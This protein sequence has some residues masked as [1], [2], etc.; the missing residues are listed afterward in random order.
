MAEEK[1]TVKERKLEYEISYIKLNKHG[2][3]IYY[4][5]EIS[6]W[7]DAKSYFEKVCKSKNFS[8]LQLKIVQKFYFKEIDG[9]LE[10]ILFCGHLNDLGISDI[11]GLIESQKELV[12]RRNSLVIEF[13]VFKAYIEIQMKDLQERLQEGCN[14]FDE[15]FNS[16]DRVI[17][18]TTN[19]LKNRQEKIDKLKN[20]GILIN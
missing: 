18:E 5:K 6:S 7:E 2:E 14:E 16:I 4:K 1:L 8:G 11:T 19:L 17:G 3:P 10:N 9:T 13:N 12:T 20:L 15:K